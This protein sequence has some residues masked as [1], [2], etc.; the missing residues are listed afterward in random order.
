MRFF[1]LGMCALVM[2]G[3]RG[4]KIIPVGFSDGSV[5]CCEIVDD[6]QVVTNMRC[7][8]FL[9]EKVTNFVRLKGECAK[10]IQAEHEGPEEAL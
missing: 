7:G 1:T 9:F 8:P 10:N 6:T 3:C 2:V 5:R 4:P